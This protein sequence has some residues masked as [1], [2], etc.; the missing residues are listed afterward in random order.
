MIA[1]HCSAC[2]SLVNRYTSRRFA[3]LDTHEQHALYDYLYV[4]HI[5]SKAVPLSHVAFF[6]A[7]IISHLLPDQVNL[8]YQPF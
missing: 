8:H 2:Y 5:E 7:D 1:N 4:S 6:F 3:H